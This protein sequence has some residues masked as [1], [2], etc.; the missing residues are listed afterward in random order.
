MRQRTATAWAY[1]LAQ[2]IRHGGPPASTLRLAQLLRCWPV[3]I[4]EVVRPVVILRKPTPLPARRHGLAA[5]LVRHSD[6]CF[7]LA[8]ISHGRDTHP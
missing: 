6:P 5:I 1:A 3:R 8:Q 4:R 7:G 2:T